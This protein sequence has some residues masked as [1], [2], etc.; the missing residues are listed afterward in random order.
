MTA[1][2]SGVSINLGNSAT[3]EFANLVEVS[4]CLFS[5]LRLRGI[6]IVRRDTKA[7]RSSDKKMPRE[8]VTMAAD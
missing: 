8:R 5:R 2:N 3:A 4:S 6:L 1:T 7:D